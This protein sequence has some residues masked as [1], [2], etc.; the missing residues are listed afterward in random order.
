[1]ILSCQNVGISFSEKNIIT[2]ASFHIEDADK[3]ALVGINGAGKT[4]L[5]RILIGA[6]QPDEGQVILSKGK[7]IGYLA[8]NAGLD[9]SCTILEELTQAKQEMLDLEARI[10]ESELLMKQVSGLALQEVM[11]RYTLLTHEYERKGG[12]TFRSE[13]IGV[14]KG[15][16][17]LEDEFSK[18]CS[19]LSGGQKTRVALGKLLLQSPDL[20]I[21]DEPTNHLDLNSIAWLEGYL[22]NY[23]GA[24]LVVSHDRYFLEKLPQSY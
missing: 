3:V 22:A 20:I 7:T 24:V 19:T 21:L 6:Q 12:Y 11:D 4:T 14:L 13:I 17:F 18:M 15:L 23:K 10:Q 5:L 16:G 9:F 1:M 8:Q 2:G